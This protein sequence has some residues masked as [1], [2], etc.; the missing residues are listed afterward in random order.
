MGR[1]TH[2]AG[3]SRRRSRNRRTIHVP[4]SPRSRTM[5]SSAKT[6]PVLVAI[7]LALT[8][9]AAAC[10]SK[11]SAESATSGTA[12]GAST[13][14]DITVAASGPP[15]VGGT[16]NVALN[17]ESDGWDPTKNR[18][19]V[20]GTQV[21]LAVFDP[22]AAYDVDGIAQPYLAESITPNADF[23]VW[24]ITLRPGITF[25]DG[26][27]LTA[28]VLKTIF[29]AHKASALT[30]PAIADLDSVTI[31]GTLSA[32]FTMTEPWAAF[33]SSLTGQLGMVP[34]PGQLADPTGTTKP[35]GTGPFTMTSWR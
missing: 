25:S 15:H 18:W 19:A 8:L 33:P 30:A 26:T 1:T 23:T 4:P 13:T 12:A 27:P 28:D 6:R 21:G 20:A 24:T 16:L 29:A 17:G 31:T 34:S 3:R 11:K 2:S 10:G 14:T 35:V 22:L 7:V 9:F 32:V 5:A